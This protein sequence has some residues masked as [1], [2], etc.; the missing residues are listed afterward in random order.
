[1]SNV[2]ASGA[3][4]PAAVQAREYRYDHPRLYP[5]IVN[6][7]FVRASDLGPGDDVA[8]FNLATIDGGSFRSSDLAAVGK[9]VLLVFGSRTCPVT[10]S[11]APGLKRLHAVHGER[12]RFVMVNVRE[13]HPGH[14]IA[15]PQTF[16]QKRR[17]AVDLKDH[18]HLPFEVAVDDIDG[19]FHRAF[20]SRPNSAFLISPAGKIVFGAQWANET[21]A[22][23]NALAAVAS[24]QAP[25]QPAVTRTFHAMTW[26]IGHMSPVLKAAGKGASFD[27]W[28]VVPPLG[29]MMALSNLFF[30]LPREQRG[31]PAMLLMLG[32]MVGLGAAALALGPLAVSPPAV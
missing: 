1:M 28:S 26:M 20:G 30:F 8:P 2:S 7:M 17:H 29:A 10:E 4:A 23:D 5:D 14:T 12:V 19:T 22:I 31:L 6:D 13:A 16:D 11:A 32:V 24:G 21:E 18:H 27:T 3:S 15:Q 25:R 9:P